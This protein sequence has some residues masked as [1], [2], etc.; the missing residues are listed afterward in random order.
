MTLVVFTS[1]ITAQ[2]TGLSYSQHQDHETLP[3]PLRVAG[4]T[5]TST[6]GFRHRA[7]E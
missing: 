2:Q 6:R 5:R 7:L 4:E 1:T 3:Q